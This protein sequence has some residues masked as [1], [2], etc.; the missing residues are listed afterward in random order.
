MPGEQLS[1]PLVQMIPYMGIFLVFYF[2]VLKPE[3]DRQT[4]KK[5]KLAAIKKNDHVITS[6]G[7]HGTVVNIK[8]SSI[9]LRVDDNTKIE[10]EKEAIAT[11]QANN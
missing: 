1:N 8:S 3:K 7:I 9:I 11:I 4:E 6:G 5:N 2:L 10:V